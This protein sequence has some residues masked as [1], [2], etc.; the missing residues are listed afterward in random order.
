MSTNI[1]TPQNPCLR[2]AV[3]SVG[4]SYPSAAWTSTKPTDGVMYD[5]TSSLLQPKNF[6]LVQ[7]SPF[8]TTTWATSGTTTGVRFVAWN[9]YTASDGTVWWI[10]NVIA[11]ISLLFTTGTIPTATIDIG[12]TGV[13]HR[14]FASAVQQAGTPLANLY[15]PATA[16]PANTEAAEILFDPIGFQLLQAQFKA[17]TGTPTMGVFYAG[18]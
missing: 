13:A 2:V 4:A 16:L 1:I 6:S 11:D 12:G 14:P 10:G 9:S 3:A 8:A 17:V 5:A 7:A 15:S 18:L